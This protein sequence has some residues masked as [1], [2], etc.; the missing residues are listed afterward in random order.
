MN[1]TTKRR[2]RYS[3][4]IEKRSNSWRIRY[5]LPPDGSSK[6][7]Q[8]SETFRGTKKEASEKLRDRMT[9]LGKG[10]YIPKNK[11]SVAEYMKYWMQTYAATNTKLRT[12]QG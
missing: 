1:T 7:K 8:K 2:D 12:Q 9:E 10:G 4:S 5:W 3:G 11:Q 6:R